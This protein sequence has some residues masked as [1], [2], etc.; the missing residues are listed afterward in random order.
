MSQT[1]TFSYLCDSNTVIIVHYLYYYLS[2]YAWS[3]TE[4]SASNKFCKSYRS[5][6][7]NLSLILACKRVYTCN[8]PI[9]R[10]LP[11]YPISEFKSLVPDNLIRLMPSFAVKDY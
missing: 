3:F 11:Y 10:S 5:F 1:A 9:T 7:F 2:L 4:L 8:I 6:Y